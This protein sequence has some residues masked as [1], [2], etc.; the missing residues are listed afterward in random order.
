MIF[1]KWLTR[2]CIF[3]ISTTIITGCGWALNNR[4][5]SK[6]SSLTVKTQAIATAV[7]S[8]Q[9]VVSP[10]TILEVAAPTG[11]AVK[12]IEKPLKADHTVQQENLT[13]NSLD[14]GIA[15]NRKQPQIMGLVLAETQDQVVLKYGNPQHTYVM[16]D[17]TEPITINE[18]EGFS[19]GF[20][21]AKQLI[22]ITVSSAK[23]NPGL[24]GLTVGQTVNDA[25]K[26]LGKPDVNTNY[27]L[28]YQSDST[29]LKLDVNPKTEIITSIKLFGAEK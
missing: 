24:S 15:Y 29:I 4:L 23:V 6:V 3:I 17:P 7:L 5:A 11:N 21:P 14:K 10:S 13:N 19:V 27:V 22:F 12:Y 28:T 25:V 16:D 9:A 26:A 8:T 2:G 18:Y 20:S 1:N